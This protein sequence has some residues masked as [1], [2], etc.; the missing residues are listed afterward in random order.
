MQERAINHIES[1]LNSHARYCGIPKI[2]VLCNENI[3]N[4]IVW[5]GAGVPRD[6]ISVFLQALMKTRASEQKAVSLESINS[7]AADSL[8]DKERQATIDSSAPISSAMTLL[9]DIKSFCIQIEKKNAFLTQIVN[10]N[11]DFEDLQKLINFRFLH[12]I[13]KSI[14]P[15]KLAKRCQAL[16][17][18]YGFYLGGVRASKG[19]E[20]FNKNFESSPK[21]EDLRK[22]PTFPL[23]HRENIQEAMKAK[24]KEAREGKKGKS[25][26][27]S[28]PHKK[29]KNIKSI[30][31]G[32]KKVSLKKI[33]KRK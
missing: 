29:G 4:R 27:K 15:N 28:A 31:K 30:E 20:L 32:G 26:S 14:T 5:V 8:V 3:I 7:S 24:R 25:K 9:E 10:N 1:I 19:I 16:I 6:A 13:H 17:L 2:D 22:L 21:Y 18:D 33:S 11:D 23:L 12:I